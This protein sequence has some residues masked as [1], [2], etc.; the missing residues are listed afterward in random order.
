MKRKVLILA[1]WYPTDTS[2]VSGIFIQDQAVILSRKY[3]VTV[4]VPKPAG[5]RE[6]LKGRAGPK[7][8]I[9]Q[10]AGLT[11]YRE[12]GLIY[13]PRVL[14]QVYEIYHRVTRHHPEIYRDVEDII[15]A[16]YFDSYGRAAKRGFE[17]ILA[18]WGKPD[19]IHAHVVLPGGW[20]AANLGKRYGV[21]VVLTEHS[22]PFSVHLQTHYQR[23]LVKTTFQQVNHV[24]AVSP[25][26]L[27]QIQAV[28]N[29]IPVSV[30]GE[31]VK[32]EFFVVSG[33]KAGQPAGS[34]TR[35]LS[36]ALLTEVKGLVYLLEA[37]KLLVQR[38]VQSFELI[39]GGDGP[40]RPRLEQMARASGLSDR[41]RFLGLLTPLEVR[42]WIQQCDVFVMPSLHESFCIALC[43]AM[44][45]GKPVIS[46]RCGGPEYT[47]TP[48]TGILVEVANP[49]ALADA[50]E[51]FI[52]GKVKYDP[53]LIR[54][55]VKDRFGE[56]AFLRNISRV[57]EEVWVKL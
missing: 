39:I 47:V 4:L 10:R 24:I 11:V 57:Y 36:I 42:N 25:A 40:E 12:R 35:F 29:P 16:W 8:H 22:G 45:C 30:I 46:T 48:N 26:L 17:A 52:L 31:V 44:A 15:Y 1:S 43:E 19:I 38:G 13:K 32:T 27:R 41:C 33:D 6:V 56:E 49:E 55:S 28:Q 23:Y 53:H 3:D 37:A 14:A 21:P 5:W 18:T 7:S 51:R 9:E 34:L 20:A 50:M 2:P 54:Q